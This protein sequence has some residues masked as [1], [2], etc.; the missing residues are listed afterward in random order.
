MSLNLDSAKVG[1]L[2]HAAST[3]PGRGG[4]AI[5]GFS[6]E[7]L[8]EKTSLGDKTW[9]DWL[10]LQRGFSS[11]PYEQLA[12][13]LTKAGNAEDAKRVLIEKERRKGRRSL[14]RAPS[15]WDWIWYC[16]L[17]PIISYGTTPCGPSGTAWPSS[18]SGT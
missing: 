15:P 13:V 6:Y 16:L 3:W 11:G 14:A 1:V 17:G 2:H 7:L 12:T 18:S 9:L 8:D 4:L 10:G 5:D